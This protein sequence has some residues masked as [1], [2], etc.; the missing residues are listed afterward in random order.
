M[1]LE[2]EKSG[3][4]TR[5]RSLPMF[6]LG[7]VLFPHMLLP[8]HIFE[9]RYRALTRDCLAGD[10]CFGIVLIG[11]GEEVG[12]RNRR[13]SLGTI[14]HI[15]QAQPLDDGRWILLAIGARRIR[16][17]HWLPEHPYPR[18]EVQEIEDPPLGADAEDLA[19][20]TL[21]V[22]RRVNVLR[23]ELGLDDAPFMGELSSDPIRA[24]YEAAAIARLGSLDAQRLLE[25]PSAESRLKALS[26][27]LGEEARTLEQRLADGLG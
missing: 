5:A 23:Y 7:A 13:F 2:S 10:R 24:S 3:V 17:L 22:L 1:K 19:R 15:R 27:L 14:A 12:G 20:E 8:L 11:R 9:P 16:V 4:R 6:P 25:L 18:A 26:A 21:R